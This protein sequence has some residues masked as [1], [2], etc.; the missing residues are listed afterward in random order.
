MNK[1]SKNEKGFGAVELVLVIVIIALIGAVGFLIYKN[2]HQPVKVVTIKKTIVASS[3]KP[4]TS[5][6]QVKLTQKYLDITQLGIKIPLTSSIADLSYIW[7]SNHANLTS[8]SYYNYVNQEDPSC[9]NGATESTL[10]LGEINTS[11]TP[12]PDNS[13]ISTIVG[14]KTYYFFGPQDGCDPSQTGGSAV[15]T[16][17]QTIESSI[18]TAF[19]NAQA[20]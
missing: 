10:Y 17:T 6:S 12:P 11:T 20:D 1:L 7:D 5:S 19:K 8:Q 14:S 2:K 9:S 3:N 16:Y 15:N 18:D 13:P 4:T